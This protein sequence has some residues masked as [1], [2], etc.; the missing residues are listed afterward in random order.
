MFNVVA[1]T[2]SVGKTFSSLLNYLTELKKNQSQTFIIK[3][4]KRFHDANNIAEEI[5][6]LMDKYKTCFSK[7]DFRKYKT[8]KKKFNKRDW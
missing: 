5:F 8:L 7:K 6:D 1:I 3:E 2:E 4:N